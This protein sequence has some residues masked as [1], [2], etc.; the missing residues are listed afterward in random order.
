[1]FTSPAFYTLMIGIFAYG[2]PNPRNLAIACAV[3]VAAY[4]PFCVLL[5]LMVSHQILKLNSYFLFARQC[6][7][8][9]F[10]PCY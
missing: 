3:I 2:L 10:I 9:L 7:V 4:G 5:H 6:P 1:M 8:R